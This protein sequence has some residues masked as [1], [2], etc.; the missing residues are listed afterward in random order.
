M[1]NVSILIYGYSTCI[2]Y[3]KLFRPDTQKKDLY[4]F[5][6]LKIH[7]SL[8][9]S[10]IKFEVELRFDE[11]SISFVSHRRTVGQ[12]EGK[13][14]QNRYLAT[15][16]FLILGDCRW[17]ITCQCT[18]HCNFLAWNLLQIWIFWPQSENLWLFMHNNSQSA[19]LHIF[20]ILTINPWKIY[21]KTHI[22]NDETSMY[23]KAMIIT[24]VLKDN[25]I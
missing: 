16:Q 14:C 11:R 23:Q 13:V 6:R 25:C 22:R 7:L 18:C 5:F 8:L 3:T 19:I 17:K 20:I 15:P 12:L 2:E 1:F 24:C 4:I 10:N 21:L 9:S